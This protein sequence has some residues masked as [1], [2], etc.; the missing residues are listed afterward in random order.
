MVTVEKAT[1]GK[2]ANMAGM[3]GFGI[4]RKVKGKKLWAH[5]LYQSQEA[6]QRFADALETQQQ[7]DVNVSQDRPYRFVP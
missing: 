7:V 1:F 2:L 5:Y 3:T 6:A 4:Y